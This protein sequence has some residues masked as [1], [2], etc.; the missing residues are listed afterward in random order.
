MS[1]I[2]NLICFPSILIIRAPNSTP[3]VKSCTG[4]K[5]LSVNCRSRQD[6][7]TPA[8]TRQAGLL[9]GHNFEGAAAAGLPRR[10][11]VEAKLCPPV[12]P[13]IMY[14][15]RY[16]QNTGRQALGLRG[17]RYSEDEL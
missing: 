2:C 16:L 10:S 15:K 14:L 4:W 12:S 13:I 17:S 8:Q 7:P 6:F 11:G 1:Q 5:R 9:G 3:M